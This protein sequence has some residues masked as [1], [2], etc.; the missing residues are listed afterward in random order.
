ML[1][2]DDNKLN[3]KVIVK[4][5]APYEVEVIE[6][7]SGNECLDILDKDTDFDLIFMDD[8]MPK[9]SGTETLSIIK[10]VSRIDGYYIPIVVLTANVNQG[11]KEKYLGVGFDDYL[12]KP[13]DKS[14]LARVL[15]KYLKVR[16]SK[17]SDKE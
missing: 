10:K 9:L 1:V 2:V 7:S 5:L 15:K 11:I 8:M 14:E 17:N 12:S 16:K 4:M 6:A 13:I 3:L